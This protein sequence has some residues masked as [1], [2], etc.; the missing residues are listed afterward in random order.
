MHHN[1]QN[2]KRMKQKSGQLNYVLWVVCILAIIRNITNIVKSITEL[3]TP[4][5]VDF[6]GE[7]LLLSNHLTSAFSLLS[8]LFII[9]AVILTLNKRKIGVWGFFAVQFVFALISLAFFDDPLKQL[10]VS[11]GLAFIH[12]AV[13]FCLLLIKRNGVSSLRVIFSDNGESV[14]IKERQSLLSDFNNKRNISDNQKI[15]KE[16]KES[17]IG[18]DDVDVVDNNQVEQVNNNDA[19][20]EPQTEFPQNVLQQNSYKKK[21]YSLSLF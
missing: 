21:S 6:I 18:N 2:H 10:P 9:I 14:Q 7:T 8:S 11:F 13:F 20:R 3:L 19:E 4:E 5:N 17:V 12:S 15:R 1:L 16:E